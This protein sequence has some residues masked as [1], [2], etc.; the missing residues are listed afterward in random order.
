MG[1]P[2]RIELTD[3]GLLIFLALYKLYVKKVVADADDQVF[4]KILCLNKFNLCAHRR[5]RPLTL[6]VDIEIFR[7][8]TTPTSSYS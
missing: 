8:R 1:Y 4:K 5:F 7:S 3:N 6:M 2:V